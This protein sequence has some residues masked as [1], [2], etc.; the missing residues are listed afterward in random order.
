MLIV[1][2]NCTH[3]LTRTQEKKLENGFLVKVSRIC[4]SLTL[5]RAI[6]HFCMV[7]QQQI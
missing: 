3:L 4:T 2:A 7:Y 1:F 6:V 5:G